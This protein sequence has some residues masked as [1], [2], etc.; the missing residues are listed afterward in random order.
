MVMA[1]LAKN[2]GKTEAL[3]A[4]VR[5]LEG[6]G[7]C[8]GITS[9]GRD[10]ETFDVLNHD[11]V[12]P[13]IVVAAGGLVATGARLLDASAGEWEVLERTGV[14]TAYGE[15]QVARAQARALVEVAG[16]VA[17]SATRAAARTMRRLGADCVVVDGAINRRAAASPRLATGV[18][19]AVGAVLGGGPA[20]VAAA[21]RRA[22]DVL[23]LPLATA[24]MSP[25]AASV[26]T[27]RRGTRPLRPGFG[28]DAAR[29][30][31]AALAGD[32]DGL[33]CIALHGALAAQA[34]EALGELAQRAGG[35]RVT[36]ADPTRLVADD[37]DV[38]R[39]RAVGLELEVRERAPVLAVT[40][41]SGGVRG[42]SLDPEEL[43]AA[44][45]AAVPEVPVVDVRRGSHAVPDVAYRWMGV[46]R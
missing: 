25:S 15:V 9:I 28:L 18:V 6:R 27:G 39:H 33:D 12:K 45:T 1:G 29:A 34:L 10:G 3:G 13:R 42:D 41:N 21:A 20:G 32:L 40:V 30:E 8:V 38:A 16:P 35:L 31:V 7:W 44:V 46:N 26:A 43:L 24:P 5:M 22:M 19:L 23:T 4:I 11:L 17:V 37:A 2:T 36:L 14:H